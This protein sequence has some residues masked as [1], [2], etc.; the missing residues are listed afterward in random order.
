[1]SLQ[2]EERG[3]FSCSSCKRKL[4]YE[5]KYQCIV[6]PNITICKVCFGVNYHDK[7]EFMLRP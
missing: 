3:G 4:L 7:H 2:N 6:C 5:A 1:M